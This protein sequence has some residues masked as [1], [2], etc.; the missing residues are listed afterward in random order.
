M[1]TVDMI[2]IVAAVSTGLFT[3]LVMT[4]LAFFQRTWKDLTDSEF[5]LEIQ[6]FLGVARTH[7]LNYGLVTASVLAPAAALILFRGSAE[8]PAFVLV[9]AGLVT[10]IAGPV[11]VSRFFVEPI[12]DV[13][14]GWKV[15]APPEG[16]RE[17]RDRYFRLNVIR[18]LGS[19]A[20]FVLFLAGLALA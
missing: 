3:G 12:Y 13:F 14:L 16:W 7:P 9:L 5:S 19:G 8:D 18:F 17:A 10:F 11:L 20:A 2:L 4:L 6:K 15:E 1:T